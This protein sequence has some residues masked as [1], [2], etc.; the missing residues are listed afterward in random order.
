MSDFQNG[1]YSF[2]DVTCAFFGPNISLTVTG[3][4]E[5]GYSVEQEGDKDSLVAATPCTRCGPP[6]TAR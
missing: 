5:E 1:V 2:Q 3:E 4:A 6:R